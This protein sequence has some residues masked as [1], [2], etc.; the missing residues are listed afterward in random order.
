VITTAKPLNLG[1]N[2]TQQQV[3]C[4]YKSSH[5]KHDR[6]RLLAVSMAYENS[7]TQ[8]ISSTI[9]RGRATIARWIKAYKEGGTKQLIKRSHEG[10]KASLPQDIQL[11]LI[12]KLISGQYKTA[13]EIQT[14][15]QTDCGVCLKLS[16][17]YYWLRQLRASWKLPRPNHEKRDSE[18]REIFKREILSRLESLAI[19]IHRNAHIWVEDEHRYGLMNIIRRCWTLK[20]HRPNVSH[21][22]R[23]EWGYI[24]GAVDIVTGKTEFI[25]SP[26]VSLE[27]SN[28][29]VKQLVSTD[30]SA[31]HIILWDNAGYHPET[32]DWELSESVRFIPF[33]AYS[34]DLN[35]IEPLWNQVKQELGNIVW[36]TLENMETGID[37]ALK[38]YWTDVKRV[39]SLVGNTWLTR[40]VIVFLQKRIDQLFLLNPSDYQLNTG[41]G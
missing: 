13:K 7:S 33:P 31:I 25:Y 27:W 35:P 22:D 6:E 38:P 5:E 21:N 15:L 18:A 12:E 41:Y 23:Y 36:S 24:Y 19:P 26:S 29:F 3:E 16:A 39:W 37:K 2:S 11:K 10:R 8:F 9:K 34:P 1:I 17:I 20:G 28:E 30:P 14:W 32:L 40:A 4:Q